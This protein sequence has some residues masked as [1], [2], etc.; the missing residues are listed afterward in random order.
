MMAL[1]ADGFLARRTLPD[2]RFAGVLPLTYGRARL[3]V[4]P[5][6]DCGWFQDQW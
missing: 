5:S 4:G 1:D 3:G 2:G 6:A